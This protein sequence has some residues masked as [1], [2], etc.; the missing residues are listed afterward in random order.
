M[1]PLSLRIR[2][3]YDGTAYLGWQETREGPSIQGTLR[4]L[5][6]QILQAPVEVEAASRTDA[7]VHASGQVIVL[8]CKQPRYSADRFLQS[9]SRLLPPDIAMVT[10]DA[11]S[12][13]FHPTLDAI[14]K[15][16]LY[17]IG[18]RPFPSRRHEI[19]QLPMSG[20]TMPD[21]EVMRQA[22][23]LLIG[24]HNF[25][26]FAVDHVD[27]PIKNPICTLNTISIREREPGLLV[28]ELQ[29]DRFLYKMCRS[30]V[31]TVLDCGRGRIDPAQI[32]WILEQQ[33]RKHA[34]ICAPAHGLT[35]LEVHYPVFGDRTSVE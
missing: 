19:W 10:A 4:S 31:G 30:I 24:T 20:Q 6:S 1:A 33:Q 34:G 12:T 21:Q 15:T 13:D 7:G 27:N 3:A 22:A 26:A 23:S 9:L 16:Y 32:P 17:Q 8:R 5:A 18:L 28:L 2:L 11:V 35:L 14:G 29:G 25:S